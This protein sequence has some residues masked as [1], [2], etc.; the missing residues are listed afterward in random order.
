MRV[1]FEGMEITFEE[2]RVT[3]AKVRY[4]GDL[5]AVGLAIPNPKDEFNQEEGRRIALGR[6]LETFIPDPG[7]VERKVDKII[8]AVYLK[9]Q[10]QTRE[11]LGKINTLTSQTINRILNNYYKYGVV[12]GTGYVRPPVLPDL[13]PPYNNPWSRL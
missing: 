11:I 9:A 3:F 6:A 2:R 13:I 4:K 5:V 7:V 1:N 10:R 8:A 12:T